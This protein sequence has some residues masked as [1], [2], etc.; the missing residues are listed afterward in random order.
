MFTSPE[1]P[2]RPNLPDDAQ[3]LT[4]QGCLILRAVVWCNRREWNESRIAPADLPCFFSGNCGLRLSRLREQLS[5][6]KILRPFAADRLIPT[7]QVLCVH[8]SCVRHAI[9]QCLFGSFYRSARMVA[10]RQQ[11]AVGNIARA[12]HD[13]HD[14]TTN[15]HGQN[16]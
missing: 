9:G 15:A 6:L 13:H 11:V 7:G 5:I 16:H 12:F 14:D 8:Q 3:K 10:V 4:T 1:T 2:A